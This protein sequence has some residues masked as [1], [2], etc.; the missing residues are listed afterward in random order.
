MSDLPVLSQ[1]GTVVG[2]TSFGA[3]V[4]RVS[5]ALLHTLCVGYARHRRLGT[6][7]V[8]TRSMVA[9]STKKIYRQKGTGRA[10]HGSR[11]A[12]LFKGGGVVH[13][14]IPRFYTLT[15]PRLASRR[16]LGYCLS[17][18]T[19]SGDVVIVDKFDL[20]LRKTKSFIAVLH[21][22]KLD[23]ES[24]LLVLDAADGSDSIRLCARNVAKVTVKQAK[25]VCIEDLLSTSKLLFT[26]S[27]FEQLMGRV[28]R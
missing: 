26:K 15:V 17:E 20:E 23:H 9:G 27:S 16:A 18:R 1:G 5:N 25:D 24:V 13:G 19:K 8:K 3:P 7:S 11:R 6:A 21:N 12:N 4:R 28:E 10:R 22:L 2:T 14:P